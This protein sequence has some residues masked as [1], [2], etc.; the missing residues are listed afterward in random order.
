MRGKGRRRA[1]SLSPI[2]GRDRSRS[3]HNRTNCYT[4]NLKDKITNDEL[5]TDVKS[6]KNLYFTLGKTKKLV[7]KYELNVINNII[8]RTHQSHVCIPL[9]QT[10]KTYSEENRNNDLKKR[11]QDYENLNN[12]HFK[13]DIQRKKNEITPIENEIKEIQK[14]ATEKF[15]KQKNEIGN[16][17]KSNDSLRIMRHSLGVEFTKFEWQCHISKENME[18]VVKEHKKNETERQK[19]F[20]IKQNEKYKKENNNNING[21]DENQNEVIDW[22]KNHST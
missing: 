19:K 18:K 12:L 10:S 7:N 17:S 22:Q 21:L 5:A 13:Q 16:I 1:R 15:Q 8:P 11:T 9:S 14:K 2:G 6:I 3:R 4:E 20:I